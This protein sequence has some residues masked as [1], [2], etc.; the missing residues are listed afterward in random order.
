MH[1]CCHHNAVCCRTTLTLP[2]SL[3]QLLA[4][5]SNYKVRIFWH[6]TVIGFTVEYDR[7][8]RYVAIKY[9]VS[10]KRLASFAPCTSTGITVLNRGRQKT[11]TNIWHIQRTTSIR[12]GP[13]SCSIEAFDY[14]CMNASEIQVTKVR[15]EM[16]NG[17]IK[18]FRYSDISHCR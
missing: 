14:C 5:R 11:H 4:R 10:S 6:R 9:F 3:L 2:P 18:N 7:R 1:Y 16:L 13:S 12:S 8:V 15:S 17:A